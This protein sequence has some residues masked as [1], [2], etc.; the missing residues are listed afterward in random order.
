MIGL[1]DLLEELIKM[2][3]SDLHLTVGAPPVVRVDGNSTFT[4][5]CLYDDLG[6][7][8]IPGFSAVALGLAT[9]LLVGI[10]GL[11]ARRRTKEQ[12]L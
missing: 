11:R 10:Y 1:R 2:D 9:F 4:L 6:G 3:G 5:A 8:G 7:D 12:Q